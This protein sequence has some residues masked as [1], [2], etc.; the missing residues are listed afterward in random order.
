MTAPRTT[1]SSEQATFRL[2]EDPRS[3]VHTLH[4]GQV[5]VFGHSPN[6]GFDEIVVF[7]IVHG[8][9]GDDVALPPNEIVGTAFESPRPALFTRQSIEGHNMQPTGDH[10]QVL[11]ERNG[12]DAVVGLGGPAMCSVFRPVRQTAVP[13]A[14]ENILVVCEMNH[15]HRLVQA[16]TIHVA[17]FRS[18]QRGKHPPP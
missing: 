5:P 17:A 2:H 3:L 13:A 14:R 6:G 10:D 9:Y 15:G 18:M 11:V 8:R 12:A 1:Q 16:S 4:P 7:D